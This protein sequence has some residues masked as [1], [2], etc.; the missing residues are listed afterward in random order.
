MDDDTLL[1]SASGVNAGV[2]LDGGLDTAG[3]AGAELDLSTVLDPNAILDASP[4]G[5]TVSEAT[6]AV[7]SPELLWVYCL[8]GVLGFL[9]L[10]YI[11]AWIVS[12]WNAGS[13]VQNKDLGPGQPTMIVMTAYRNMT[14]A[15]ALSAL[16]AFGIALYVFFADHGAVW[17]PAPC[18]GAGI[19][20]AGCA[21]WLGREWRHCTSRD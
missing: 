14:L 2:T 12:R 3:N 8:L 13:I 7:L 10:A 17:H 11:L 6:G 4:L 19:A 1:N 5:A 21:A 15:V 20:L 9:V 18:F 16:M